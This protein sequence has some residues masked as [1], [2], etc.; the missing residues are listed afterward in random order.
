MSSELDILRELLSALGP[1]PFKAFP[2]KSKQ[3]SWNR[4]ARL[5]K[6]HRLGSLLARELPAG[7]PLPEQV[8]TEWADEYQRQLISAVLRGDC[9]Q[10]V[11]D[12]C[13]RRGIET[14]VLK[15]GHLAESYYPHPALRPTDDLDLLIHP[16][17]VKSARA[18]LEKIGGKLQEQTAT[19]GKFLF[20]DTGIFLELHTGLQTAQRK[21]PAF[22]IRI[23]DF[24][25]DS[26]PTQLLG[27]ETRVLSPTINLLYLAAHLSH[28]S[29]S[30]LIWF[31][32]LVLLM[33]KSGGDIDWEELCRKAKEYHCAA[34]VYYPLLFTGLFFRQTNP[35]AVLGRLAPS[36]AKQAITRIFITPDKILKRKLPDRGPMAL[37]NRFLLNDDWGQ[38]IISVFLSSP[39]ISY[40]SH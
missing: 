7:L 33:E 9:L 16:Q 12:Y 1:G 8:R 2:P 35:R 23:E 32:D 17:D 27:Q 15:G 26:L 6:V 21:N 39:T 34:Q 13:A 38:A 14:I 30:R 36:Q 5:V 3:V 22:A 24:W 18:T 29:F 25:N 10:T 31:Y 40:C 19:A 11:L 37:L 4:L 28:H 20:P